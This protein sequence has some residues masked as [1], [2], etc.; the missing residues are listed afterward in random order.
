MISGKS[1]ERRKMKIVQ[2]KITLKG[3]KPAIWRRV[4]VEDNVSMRKLHE[5]LNLA[6]GW[7]ISH[8]HMFKVENTEIGN[9]DHDGAMIDDKKIRLCD[10]VKD[11]HTFEYLYDF[12][13][14]WEHVV[15][16]EDTVEAKPKEKYP[17]CIAGQNACPPED[18]GG[19]GGYEKFKE[20]M[21]NPKHP[22]HKEMKEWCGGNWDPE[23]FD[24][25]QV[26][27]NAAFRS[28]KLAASY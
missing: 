8:L 19:L 7:E 2:L 15:H 25:R 11:I 17:Q 23:I 24:H 18:V 9:A 27:K 16:V 12:G 28:R 26:N 10:L 14:G 20:I 21:S 6:M 1:T 3:S 5:I 22:E 13:D 4:Q